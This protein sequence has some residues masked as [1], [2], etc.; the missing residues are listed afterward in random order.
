MSIKMHPTRENRSRRHILSNPC[1][2]PNGIN[3]HRNTWKTCV[4]VPMTAIWYYTDTIRIYNYQQSK[5]ISRKWDPHGHVM[6]C[7]GNPVPI[8]ELTTS[9]VKTIILNSISPRGQY[10]TANKGSKI[11]NVWIHW[12]HLHTNHRWPY[13]VRT[14][15]KYG[16]TGDPNHITAV[17]YLVATQNRWLPIA[18]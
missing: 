1:K 13:L 12:W 15:Q 16:N 17:S 9:W 7:R 10:S 5:N 11:I 4:S 6:R 14:D 8:Q 3:M 18:P 2:L